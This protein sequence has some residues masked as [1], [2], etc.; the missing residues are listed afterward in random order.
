MMQQ[1][2]KCPREHACLGPAAA[3]QTLTK[4]AS[5]GHAPYSMMCCQ[6]EGDQGRCVQH[7]QALMQQSLDSIL[8][9]WQGPLDSCLQAA[10]CS[11]MVVPAL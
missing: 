7:G 3:M 2:V 11:P 10:K 6:S 9:Q 4:P 8:E 5:Q 1:E